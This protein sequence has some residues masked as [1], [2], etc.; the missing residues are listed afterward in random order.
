MEG[1]EL[2]IGRMKRP[3][4]DRIMKEEDDEKDNKKKPWR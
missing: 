4:S 3:I 1:V 2:K